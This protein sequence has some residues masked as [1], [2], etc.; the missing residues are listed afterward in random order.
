[1]RKMLRLCLE[2]RFLKLHFSF[3]TTGCLLSI[4]DDVCQ[5]W[6]CG[7]GRECQR[8]SDGLPSCIC[9]RE[10]P[11]K[12][13]S[14]DVNR[15]GNSNKNGYLEYGK[16]FEEFYEPFPDSELIFPPDTVAVQLNDYKP[17]CGSDGKIYPNQC[18]LY[19]TA[20]I[21]NHPY[22]HVDDSEESCRHVVPDGGGD[23]RGGASPDYGGGRDQGVAKHRPGSNGGNRG[24]GGPPPSESGGDGNNRDPFGNSPSFLG[25]GGDFPPFLSGDGNFPNFGGVDIPFG[26]SGG[27]GFDQPDLTRNPPEVEKF[28]PNGKGQNPKS[29]GRRNEKEKV[30]DR[31]QSHGKLSTKSTGG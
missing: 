25:T 27:E 18:E 15:E 19:R 3:T 28:K 7:H 30:N 4:I 16:G 1:M 21:T 29:N 14:K 9:M 26:P 20:C 31:G 8:G 23:G 22:L 2:Y 11:D 13:P 17:V 6:W 12:P 10:C 24:N 5:G